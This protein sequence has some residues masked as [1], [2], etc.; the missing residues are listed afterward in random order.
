MNAYLEQIAK[1]EQ[2]HLSSPDDANDR[3]L[4]MEQMVR[5]TDEA[6]KYGKRYT[7]VEE[8]M[9]DLEVDD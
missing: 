2:V 5:E 6:L 4:T 7:N 3:P 1:T 9:R 8:F